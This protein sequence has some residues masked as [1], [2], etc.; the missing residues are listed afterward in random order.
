M[1][2]DGLLPHLQEPATCPILSHINPVHGSIQFSEDPFQYYPSLYAW[3]YQVVC[4][5]PFS[6]PKPCMNLSSP[7]TR[8]MPR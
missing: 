8:Y 1:E 7:Y 6:P 2:A 5:H 4:F 3:V